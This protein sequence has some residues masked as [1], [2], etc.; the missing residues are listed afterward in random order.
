MCEMNTHYS[1]YLLQCGTQLGL[2]LGAGLFPFQPQQ[3]L[4]F[5]VGLES[6]QVDD[7]LPQGLLGR[8]GRAA[9]PPAAVGRLLIEAAV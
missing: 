8:R 1:A 7:A 2:V 9:V 3:Q 4:W 6:Q 5:P